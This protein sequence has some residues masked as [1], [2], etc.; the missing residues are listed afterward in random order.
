MS[1]R[2]ILVGAGASAA[3]LALNGRATWAAGTNHASGPAILLNQQSSSNLPT[4]REQTVVMEADPNNVWDSFNPF[5]PNG[6]AYNYGLAQISREYMFYTNFL[7]G[8]IKPWLATKYSYNADFTECTLNLNP[9][10]KWSDGKPFTADDVVF[11]QQML[12]A[13]SN[14]GG[15]ATYKLAVK[16]VKAADAHTVVWTLTSTQPR[17]HYNFLAGIISD[18]L[19]VMPKH[20]WEGQDPGTFKFNPNVQTGPYILQEASGS[21]LYYLWKKNPDY[22][23]KA[24]LDPKP[25]Y[26]L[27]RQYTSIDATVQD[28]LAGNIDDSRQL[29]QDNL[30]Q[31]VIASQYDKQSKF[32]FPDP[33]PRGFNFN[34]DSPSG[35]FATP[36][37]RWA[38]SHLIDRDTIANTIWQP[39]SRVATYPWADYPDWAKW[40]TESV[41]SQFDFS[42]DTD[43]ANKMLD[44]LGST[45]NGDVRSLNGKPLQLNMITPVPTNFIEFQIGQTFGDAA[46]GVGIKINQKSLPG[47]AWGDAYAT[48]DWDINNSWICGMTFDP[49]QLYASYHSRN[50][51]PIGTRTTSGD[52]VRLKSKALDA[53]I[54]KMDVADP[55]NPKNRAVFD[56]GLTAFMTELPTVASVQTIYPMMRNT[57]HW[58]GWPTEDN[59]YT[60]P[61]SWWGQY[62][63]VIGA[64]QPAGKQ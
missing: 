46:K 22:W 37:G 23:N 30:N 8:E 42:Y 44:E 21:K 20:I 1:R 15:A 51:V 14:L 19:R 6:E 39:K 13:N 55:T 10:V 63:F 17:F 9:A 16:D 18:N 45:R 33:C 62:L 35:L 40:A 59:P 61:A 38:L 29:T 12:L 50:Y 27:Y 57:A 25:E 58:T 5:I 60:I 2:S 34:V 3:A 24:A 47:S 26:I 28:F 7:T 4:P 41:M 48:G 64:L 49:D 32:N 36:Q 31:Q 52:D 54:D 11:T 43:K 53:A 56:E